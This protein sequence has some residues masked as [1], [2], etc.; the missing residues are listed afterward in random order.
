MLI[1]PLF[2]APPYF[3]LIVGANTTVF[4]VDVPFV[5][6]SHIFPVSYR[7]RGGISPHP[8]PPPSRLGNCLVSSMYQ[9]EEY[10]RIK[11]SFKITHYYFQN[12]QWRIR[13]I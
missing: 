11:Q 13:G 4:M 1:V 3:R 8:I 5:P 7:N 9:C 10:C 2:A 12:T 6:L